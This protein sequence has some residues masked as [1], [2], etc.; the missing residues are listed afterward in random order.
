MPLFL[1]L[2]WAFYL[3]IS[4]FACLVLLLDFW[5]RMNRPA[6]DVFAVPAI[7]E[8]LDA[9]PSYIQARM[10]PLALLLIFA[11]MGFCLLRKISAG[12]RP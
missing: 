11:A 8:C 5:S 2:A 4:L 7:K 12:P 1:A 3:L 10:A 9:L 6:R